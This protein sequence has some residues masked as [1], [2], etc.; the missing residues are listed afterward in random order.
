MTDSPAQHLSAA[1]EGVRTFNHTSMATATDWE[2]PS[3]SYSALG[4]LSRLVGM[5]EQAVRQST[6]PVTHTHDQGRVLIDG[7]GDADAAVI[8]LLAAQ[9]DAQEAA[10][11]LTAAVHRMH[12]AS[13]SMGLD[14]R[15]M[16]QFED[17]DEDDLDWS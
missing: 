1:A 16:P 12:S 3:H 2:F 8:E 13:S 10:A 15:G 7:G 14:T 5:L 4:S 6:L 17:D 9:A 11:A